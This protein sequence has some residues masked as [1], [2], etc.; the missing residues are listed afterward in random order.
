MTTFKII[1]DTT[2][3]SQI[4]VT[5]ITES[6]KIAVLN[7]GGPQG[8][9]GIQGPTGATGPT[10]QQGIQGIK[11]D[12]GL[13]GPQGPTGPQGLQG[14]QGLTGAT[15]AQGIQGIKGDTGA[16]GATGSVGPGVA[17]DG[18][19]GQLLIKNSATNYD[20]AWSSLSSLGI[21]T[22]SYVD[23][24]IANLV[25]SAP[26]T[27]DTL[28]EL[29]TAL[30]NDPNFA[31]TVTNSIAGK[32]SLTGSYTNPSWL[33]SIPFS[34]LTSTPTTLSGYG[35][36]DALTSATAA[37]TYQP[38]AVASTTVSG[39][40]KVDGTTITIND[41]GVIS[42]TPTIP[43]YIQTTRPSL[44]NTQKYMWWD[45]TGGNLSLWIED[46]T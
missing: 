15:G 33:V 30:G 32:V 42:S 19:T 9:Q 12:T 11:G 10:G 24:S 36:T 46:G 20:T 5:T 14:I 27:L 23:T 43:T 3:S 25:S 37:S 45:T 22:S 28:N 16:T 17:I 4:K 29:A 41:S 38:I 7:F 8:T 6:S 1:P 35:I 31:T 40:V 18:T 34:K 39:T 26:A 13:T 21:A 44:S 2:Q